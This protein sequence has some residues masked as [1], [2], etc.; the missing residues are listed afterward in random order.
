MGPVPIGDAVAVDAIRVDLSEAR[1]TGRMAPP[2][3]SRAAQSRV[4]HYLRRPAR[5][6]CLRCGAVPRHSNPHST[7][8]PLGLS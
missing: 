7:P 6:V 2:V 3:F 8:G 5:S 1:L 4:S